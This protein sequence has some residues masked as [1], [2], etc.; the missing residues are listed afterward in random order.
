MT[1]IESACRRLALRVL[2]GVRDGR[3]V[4][5]EPASNGLRSRAPSHRRLS[6]GQA[7]SELAATVEIHSP[8][9]YR[10][11]LGGTVGLGEAYRDGVWDCDELVS[12]VSD[13]SP[14]HGGPRPL[15][16]PAAPRVLARSRERSGV[17]HATA[18]AA[19]GVTSQP[20]TTSAMTSSP[21]TSTSR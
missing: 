1:A 13:R 8:H 10:A 17:S 12:L 19:R 5:I 2:S 4:L 15:A 11:M 20:T 6:F 9:F 18:A 21:S 3:L 16:P 7:D 14:E